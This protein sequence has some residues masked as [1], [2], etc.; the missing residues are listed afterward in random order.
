LSA[1]NF[2]EAKEWL[3]PWRFRAIEGQQEKNGL[4]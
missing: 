4:G 3:M 1:W 2:H